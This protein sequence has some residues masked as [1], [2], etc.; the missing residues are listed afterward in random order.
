[1]AILFGTEAVSFEALKN[2]ESP[3]ASPRIA[4]R[5]FRFAAFDQALSGTELREARGASRGNACL[6]SKNA[7][8]L[9]LRFGL[10]SRGFS[11]WYW[12]SLAIK[13]CGKTE[14]RLVLI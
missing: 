2:R 11:H 6:G 3:V 8:S 10:Q 4:L 7:V 1:M 14:S 12:C 13:T 9:S 5:G